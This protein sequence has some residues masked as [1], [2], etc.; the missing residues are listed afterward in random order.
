MPK[1]TNGSASHPL[2]IPAGVLC[3]IL[4]RFDGEPER[5]VEE[6]CEAVSPGVPLQQRLAAFREW[7]KNYPGFENE[8]ATQ[9]RQAHFGLQRMVLAALS[10]FQDEGA[11]TDKLAPEL[12]RV[13]SV[14]L[15]PPRGARPCSSR[16]GR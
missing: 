7:F 11:V 15:T 10:E 2:E 12:H 6:L 4:C 1:H 16:A 9:E 13:A 5:T 8:F 3:A 14:V